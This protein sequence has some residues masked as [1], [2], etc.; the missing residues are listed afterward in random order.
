MRSLYEDFLQDKKSVQQIAEATDYPVSS[1]N[2]FLDRCLADEVKYDLQV[3]LE[4]SDRPYITEKEW[5][6]NYSETFK[7]LTGM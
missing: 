3:D 6:D 2:D 5:A 4:K 1:V 7:R